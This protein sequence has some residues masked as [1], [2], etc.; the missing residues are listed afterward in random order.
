MSLPVFEVLAWSSIHAFHDEELRRTPS[1]WHFHVRA[2]PCVSHF[3]FAPVLYKKIK[4]NF[5]IIKK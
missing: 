4:L 2:T 3:A 5:L 1:I